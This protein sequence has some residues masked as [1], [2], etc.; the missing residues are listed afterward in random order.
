MRQ[1]PAVAFILLVCGTLWRIPQP[2]NVVQRVS[3]GQYVAN[4]GR[5]QN[6]SLDC[7]ALWKGHL[8]QVATLLNRRHHR[9]VETYS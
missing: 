7:L 8:E 9:C 3:R 1:G 6:L 2:T 4:I 5:A